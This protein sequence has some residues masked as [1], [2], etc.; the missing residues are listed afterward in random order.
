MSP[1]HYT[2]Y[3]TKESEGLPQECLKYQLM[4][5]LPDLI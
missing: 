5:E 4:C 2:T 3:V 1:H